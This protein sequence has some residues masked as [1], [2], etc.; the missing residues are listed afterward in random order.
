MWLPTRRLVGA[1]TAFGGVLAV[2]SAIPTQWYG[3][4]PTDSY[5]F[6][7][8][9]FSALWIERTVVPG[10]TV[11]AALLLLTGLLALFRRDREWMARWHRWLAVV[12]VIG[13]ATGTLATVL[14]APTGGRGVGNP[15]TAM[16]VVLGALLALLAVTL[17]FSGLV[18]W[19]TGYLRS[20]RR[21]L[22]GA[23]LGG[24]VG[25]VLIVAMS[26]ATGVEFGSLGG[27][28]VVVP[29]ATMMV[30]LGYDLWMRSANAHRT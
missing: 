30:V 26:V 25:A 3:P 4:M 2:V 21:L 28:P 11:L 20:G 12:A 27:L 24:P 18:A 10:V 8:P 7:P 19:G 14:V 15:T 29:L 9:R 22:G 6:E 23:L 13:A 5:V 17:L 16:N 1:L